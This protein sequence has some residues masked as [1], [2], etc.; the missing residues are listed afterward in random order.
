MG[1]SYCIV[2]IFYT[3]YIILWLKTKL[4]T[5]KN[6]TMTLVLS[7]GQPFFKLSFYSIYLQNTGFSTIKEFHYLFLKNAICFS[8]FF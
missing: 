4:N 3:L 2:L 5:K 1:K 6:V 8:K 7:I